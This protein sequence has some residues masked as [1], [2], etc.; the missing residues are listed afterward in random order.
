MKLCF[1]YGFS[2]GFPWLSL[3][4]T[5]EGQSPKLKL[6]SVI[7]LGLRRNALRDL[8]VNPHGIPW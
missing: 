2:Y 8:L 5:V 1:F 3:V 6:E 4:D 7:L